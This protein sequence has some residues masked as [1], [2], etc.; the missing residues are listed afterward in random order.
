[1]K[2]KLMK[3]FYITDVDPKELKIEE[4]EENYETKR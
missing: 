1:M 3:E 4:K 2:R